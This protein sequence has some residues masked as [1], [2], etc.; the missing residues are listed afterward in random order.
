MIRTGFFYFLLLT[1]FQVMAQ[2]QKPYYPSFD[3]QGHR[4]ARGMFPENTIPAFLAALQ[5]GVTTIELDV[6]IT[7]DKQVVVSH[8]PYLSPEICLSADGKE[9]ESEKQFN[10]F[11]LTYAEIA[12]CDCGYKRHERFPEQVKLKVAKPLL[13]D[14]IIQVE[15]FIKSKTKYEVDYNIEIKSVK[16][17]EGISQPGVSEFSDL[18]IQLVDEYLPL[19]RVVIQSFDMRVLQYIKKN[20]PTVRLALLIE[21]KLS[22]EENVKQLGFV[23]EIYSPYFKLITEE[24]V[25][26]I[27][28]RGMR[29]IP[30][31]V[32]ETDEMQRLKVWGVDGL[33][34]DYPN[35]AKQIGLGW[36]RN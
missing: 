14:V 11:K 3:L 30:W 4:G 8:E 32:N 12:T 33:I 21:N 25:R 34:T 24:H 13:R 15:D 5:E 31:T 26:Q 7:A 19:E 10:L 1:C 22:W 18:V 20:Y 16:G 28:N 9:I 23:P 17:E 35:R 27:K 36:M 2:Q 29:V 6:V